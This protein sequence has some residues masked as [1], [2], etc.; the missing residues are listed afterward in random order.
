MQTQID[1]SERL[2][3]LSDLL[4][5]PAVATKLMKVANSSDVS[6]R[7]MCKIIECDA[8]LS[9]ELLRIANSPIYGCGGQVRTI[10]QAAVILGTRGLRDLAA[11][12][13]AAGLF[14]AGV[15]PVVNELWQHSLG[16][17]TVARMLA[18]HVKP[19]DADEA[20]LAGLI[21][22]VG[23]LVLVTLLE[24]QYDLI[25]KSLQGDN[26]CEEEAD[27]YTMD[28]AQLG[29]ECS[30]DWG[31]PA[32]ICDAVSCHHDPESSETSVEMAQ[33]V[34]AAN[35]ISK[36]WKLGIDAELELDA[37]TVLEENKLSIGEDLLAELQE[38]APLK[39][40]ESV[41]AFGRN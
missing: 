35:Q 9:M 16:C 33:V 41:Q 18:A 28:H 21:H 40:E 32:E 30:E 8:S 10:A 12:T 15:N 34:C 7:D 19:V 23:K 1:I 6:I 38:Q 22:D 13:A 39:F 14:E 36:I 20:F 26:I 27:R 3:D 4:P 31:L 5:F 24:D 11:T 25:P 29:G 17:A 2:E 37:A